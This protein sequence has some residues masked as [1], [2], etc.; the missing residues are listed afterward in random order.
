MGAVVTQ[1]VHELAYPHMREIRRKRRPDQPE[2]KCDH[3]QQ[4]KT[5]TYTVV[6]EYRSL[7]LCSQCTHVWCVVEPGS[8]IV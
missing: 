1:F 3:C 7:S 5:P 6:K 4:L 2:A 8:K